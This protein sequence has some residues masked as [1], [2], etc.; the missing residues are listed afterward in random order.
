MTAVSD[1]L[2]QT[3]K[4]FQSLPS[5]SQFALAGGTNLAFRLN[6]RKSIDIDLFSPEIVGEDGFELIE[7]EIKDLYGDSV[8][9]IQYPCNENDQ[10]IFLR[11]FISKGNVTIKVEILQNMKIVDKIDNIDGIRLVSKKD[12]GLFKLESASNRMAKKDIYDLDY[13][14][15]ELDLVSLFNDLKAKKKKYNTDL[16]KSIFDLDNET[17]PVDDPSL[18]LEFDNKTACSTKPGHSSD[19]IDILEGSQTW[20]EAKMNWRLKM[21][22]LY[23]HLNLKFPSAT[24][25]S[26]PK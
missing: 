3:I 20:P 24:G 12:I 23:S 11:C 1:V 14:C 21:R 13:I 7:K 18:L 4:E 25:V 10:Y 9:G 19:T 26:I 17:S 6:H 16:D 22:K 5:L 15:N 8:F 2:V